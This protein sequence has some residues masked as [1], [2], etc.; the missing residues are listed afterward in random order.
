LPKP[1]EIAKDCQNL[2]GNSPALVKASCESG[3]AWG[4][5]FNFGDVW[6]FWH[7]W[8]FRAGSQGWQ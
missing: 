4:V 7:C 5:V 1:P 8:Q 3:S 6:Q 2:K